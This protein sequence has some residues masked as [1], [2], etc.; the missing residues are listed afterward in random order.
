MVVVEQCVVVV[1]TVAVEVAVA[2]H[3]R[4][5]CCL[6]QRSCH[7]RSHLASLPIQSKIQNGGIESVSDRGCFAFGSDNL[8]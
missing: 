5:R 3:F 8:M 2:P 4:C 6:A 1:A 7:G